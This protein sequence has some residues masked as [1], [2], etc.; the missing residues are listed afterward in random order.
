MFRINDTVPVMRAAGDLIELVPMTFSLPPS[1]P[2]GRPDLQ[3]QIRG[4]PFRR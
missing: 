4:P 3:F 1:G 2:K